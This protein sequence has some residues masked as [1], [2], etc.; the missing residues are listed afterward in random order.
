MLYVVHLIWDKKKQTEHAPP[1][2]TLSSRRPTASPRSMAPQ[3]TYRRRSPPPEPAALRHHE[4]TYLAPLRGTSTHAP[5]PFPATG[6]CLS[7]P[8]R[9]HLPRL[10]PWHRDP[11]AAAVPRDQSLPLSATTNPPASR[12]S[13][14]HATPPPFATTCLR[15]GSPLNLT[16]TELHRCRISCSCGWR[17]RWARRPPLRL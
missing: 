1:L 5:P 9:I 6:A 10:A 17:W 2:P 15:G 13:A 4:S 11:R 12:H 16:L 3:P 8:T 14:T 7:P